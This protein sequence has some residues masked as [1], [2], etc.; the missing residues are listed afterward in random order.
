AS[1]DSGISS[2]DLS[3]PD[4]SSDNTLVSEQALAA[5]GNIVYFDFD[6]A[7]IRPDARDILLVHAAYLKQTGKQVTLEGHADERGT[8]EY[9]MALGE[10]RAKAVRDFLV[11]Q[12]VNRSQL[13]VVSFGEER[14]A[15]YASN[16]TAW[17]KNRRVEIR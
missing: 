5:M 9:N 7:T 14:P 6:E 16:P 12:G 3:S 11:I 13:G 17:A 15:A 2:D 1:T 10:R 4:A 8:R